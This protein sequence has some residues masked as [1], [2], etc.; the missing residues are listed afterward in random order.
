MRK[1]KF[2]L[3][4]KLQKLAA[5]S[6]DPNDPAQNINADVDDGRARLVT[7]V[8]SLKQAAQFIDTSVSDVL[9][10]IAAGELETIKSQRGHLS[11][12]VTVAVPTKAEVCSSSM[13]SLIEARNESEQ[14]EASAQPTI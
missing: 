9:R 7:Y 6:I 13:N 14:P 12:L 8:L 1:N 4:T 11:V 3:P 5:N 10:R 2:Y